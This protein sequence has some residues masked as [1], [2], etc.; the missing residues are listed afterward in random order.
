MM[1]KNFLLG[2]GERLAEAVRVQKGGQPK[3]APYSF[4]E[5][6]DRVQPMLS[7]VITEL[8]ALPQEAC[9]ND[10]A[11]AILTLNP[12]YIAKSYFPSDLLKATGLEAV[13]SRA[14]RI[15]PE[16][17]S[18]N[19]LPEETNTTELF[20]C[21]KRQSLL[22]WADTLSD[23][24]ESIPGA[25]QIVEIE[26]F[27]LPNLYEKIKG[28]FPLGEQ[29]VYEIVLHANEGVAENGLLAHFVSYLN[30]IDVKPNLEKRF[31]AGGLC[32]LEVT[33][34]S[35]AAANIAKYSFVR[36]VREM[37]ELRLLNPAIRTSSKLKTRITLPD[38]EP[39]DK[40]VQVAIFDGGIP[41]DHPICKWA[42]S[43]ETNGLADPSD[44]LLE[45]GVAVTSAF[46]FG[47]IDPSKQIN[48]PFAYVD[49]Y[50]VLDTSPSQNPY[51]LYEVLDRIKNVLDECRYD[52]FNL[53][54]G[55][56]LP[57]DD[58]EIHAWTAVLDEYLSDGQTL[59]T[60]AVGNDGEGDASIQ[61]N[62]IQVPA[63]CVN[64]LAIGACDITAN[65]W[66]R[67]PYSSIG[68]GRSPGITKPDLVDF[69]GSVQQPFLTVDF[70]N[71]ELLS[72]TGGTSFASPSVLR[73]ATGIRAHF[74]D[75]LSTLAIRALLVHCANDR[76]LSKVEVGWG[77]V[78]DTIEAIV[79]SKDN[80]VRVVFQGI[81]SSSKFVRIPIPLP[82]EALSGSVT[83]KATLC[84]ATPCDAHHPENYTRSGLVVT[85]RPNKER[86]SKS[87]SSQGA[88]QH[89]S[90]KSFFGQEQKK[91]QSEDELRKDAWKWENCVSAEKNFRGSTLNE[92]VFDIHYNARS[93]GR[94]ENA[95]KQL[96]YAL[97]ITVT[98]N[99]MDDL[100]DRVARKYATQL[101]QLKPV[102]DIPI[103]V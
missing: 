73:L 69:G 5:A 34:P 102:V 7:K 93:E 16:K 100:Y 62:R 89:A 55:P 83:I 47:H 57:I 82:N 19:R 77:R 90:S 53:S 70:H 61:A 64:A 63:D 75:S 95:S 84:Y 6:K 44:D 74:G 91:Y 78:P 9:P 15:K 80:A 43:Y 50:R 97:I 20:V 11:V 14:R 18:N 32:F 58:D 37:P 3:S 17:K 31:Y 98:S 72:P 52:F 101:E 25:N 4:Q 28:Q 49:H 71:G 21:G 59:A 76:S 46:L 48:Q 29:I 42:R 45:H 22:R 66:Q 1:K 8:E 99:S 81:I 85:F 38:V 54:L 36:V 94:N 65:E 87:T 96:N 92:P 67:A 79:T 103:Q 35:S 27:R 2:K 86:K 88:P 13:G 30:S 41:R 33:A 60:I 24:D 40:G 23:W 26:E 12:E 51:E 10:Y 39:I 56:C 68:P